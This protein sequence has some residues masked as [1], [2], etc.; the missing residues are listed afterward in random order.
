MISKLG[1]L[2]SEGTSDSVLRYRRS[3]PVKSSENHSSRKHSD[4]TI[5][6]WGSTVNN[7]ATSCLAARVV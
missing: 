5:L 2:G 1:Y 6:C 7:L 4:E 3:S